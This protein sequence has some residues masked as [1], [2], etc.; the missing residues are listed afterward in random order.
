MAI[1]RK[2]LMGTGVAGIF[3]AGMA[4][5]VGKGAIDNAMDIAFDNPEADQAV[6]GTDLTPSIAMGG[7]ISGI[8]GA[9]FRMANA[10]A[11]N[12]YGANPT[13]EKLLMGT[14]GA[15]LAGGVVGGLGAGYL[16]GKKFGLKGR[17]AG[18]VGGGILGGIAGT[19]V[20]A[21]AGIAATGHYAKKYGRSSNSS[22]MTAQSLNANGNIVLGMHN[23]R[24]G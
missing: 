20:G 16:G 14:A 24:R 8:A 2:V 6:L 4:N 5:K 9:P 22:L 19:S 13:G 3:G 12:M 7:G 15:G 10:Q 1:G 23:S 18:A 17:I 11:L 21:G